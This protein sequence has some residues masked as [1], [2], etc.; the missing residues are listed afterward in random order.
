MADNARVNEIFVIN[1]QFPFLYQFV[2]TGRCCSI[3]NGFF[4]VAFNPPLRRGG[5]D[6]VLF[7]FP[8]SIFLEEDARIKTAF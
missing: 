1:L 8:S 6:S 5:G 2:R 4:F 3:E 7:F